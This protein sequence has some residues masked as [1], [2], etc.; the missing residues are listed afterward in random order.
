MNRSAI[1]RSFSGSVLKRSLGVSAVV[2]TAL[3]A[4]NHGDAILAGE[5]PD[6][7]KVALTYLVP[8][9]VASYG[10]YAAFA[11]NID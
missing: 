7:V 3:T 4:I 5:T 1:Q 9:V 8:F 2:G 11:A 10:A 6:L